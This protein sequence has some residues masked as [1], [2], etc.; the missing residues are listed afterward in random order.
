MTPHENLVSQTVLMRIIT[1]VLMGGGGGGGETEKNQ[2]FLLLQ[3]E[4][5]P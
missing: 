4:L 2:K 1:Q 3:R 5:N